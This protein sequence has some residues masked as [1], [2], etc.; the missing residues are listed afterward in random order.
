MKQRLTLA[1]TL[2]TA[3]PLAAQETWNLQQCIE[4]AISHNIRVKQQEAARDQSA[5]DLSTA[6]WSRL[7]DLNGN[8]GTSFNFGRALQDDNTYGDRNTMNSNFSIGTGVPLFTGLRI[9]HQIALQKLNLK[10]AVADLKQA[11][12]DISIQVTSAY[13]QI[14]FQEEL[15]KVAQQQVEL[16]RA[17]LERSR[18]LLENGK[19]AEAEVSEARAQVAQ[20]ELALV[21]TDNNRQLALLELS[22]LLELPSPEGFRIAPPQDTATFVPLSSPE[23]V[24]AT[25]M[26]HKPAIQAARYRLE[27][28]KHQLRIAQSGWYPQLHFG[29]GIGTSYYKLV[30]GGQSFLQQSVAPQPEQIPAVL[31]QHS[32]LQ[33]FR[34]PQPGQKCPHPTIPAGMGTG[35]TAEGA[36]QGDPAGLL[37]CCRCQKPVPQ[38]PYGNRGG[39]VGLP[40][41]E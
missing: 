32:S 29:A 20:D 9:P 30:G 2:M 10:A 13:L 1:L 35:R 15:V 5:V 41:D 36:L 23:A 24:Y 14:L 11:Q 7:P 28:T 26:Q 40:P 39:N 21:K 27:G 22:Q 8:V 25:A 17:Q 37:Q 3:L 33:P 18:V 34:N 12:E 16:S 38:Q 6:R 31:P 19:A 4:H